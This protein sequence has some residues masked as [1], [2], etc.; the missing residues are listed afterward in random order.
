MAVRKAR[1][2]SSENDQLLQ[3]PELEEATEGLLHRGLWLTSLVFGLLAQL[4]LQ[5]QRGLWTVLFYPPPPGAGRGGGG[6][7]PAALLL[8]LHG[9]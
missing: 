5:P 7:Q 3:D 2:K 8:H 9:W 6:S 1:E 4:R